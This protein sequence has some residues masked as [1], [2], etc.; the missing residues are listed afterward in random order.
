MACCGRLYVDFVRLR[1]LHRRQSE[2]FLI[3]CVGSHWD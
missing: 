2:D 1:L 3:I